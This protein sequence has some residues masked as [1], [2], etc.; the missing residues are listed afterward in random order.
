MA[1]I[2]STL[3]HATSLY[4]PTALNINY[5]VF[6]STLIIGN[7]YFS[8]AILRSDVEEPPLG[9]LS[10]TVAV[11]FLWL[12]LYQIVFIRPDAPFGISIFLHFFMNTLLVSCMAE[13]SASRFKTVQSF[14]SNDQVIENSTNTPHPSNAYQLWLPLP[15]QEILCPHPTPLNESCCSLHQPNS[16]KTAS[17]LWENPYVLYSLRKTNRTTRKVGRTLTHL[18]QS[19]VVHLLQDSTKTHFRALSVHFQSYISVEKFDLPSCPPT[20]FLNWR[21]QSIAL[22]QE[23]I[24]HCNR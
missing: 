8:V 5:P 13:S 15:F 21:K 3:T 1:K 19:T 18:I 4:H 23:G 10:F 16:L 6:F 11:L 20:P 22:K 7:Q 14:L 9:S 24:L 2:L 17:Q 12:C